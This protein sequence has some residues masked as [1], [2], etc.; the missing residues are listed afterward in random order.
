[1]LSLSDEIVNDDLSYEKTGAKNDSTA[2][3]DIG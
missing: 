3:F 1:M 2:V